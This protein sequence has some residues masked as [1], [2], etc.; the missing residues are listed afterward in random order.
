VRWL[1]TNQDCYIDPESKLPIAL[2]DYNISYEEPPEDIFDIPAIPDG[3]TLIDKRPGASQ[4]PESESTKVDRITEE[5]FKQAR[6]ALANGQYRLAAELFAKV[7]E[8][9]PHRGWAWFWLG[10]S[11]YELGEYNA[12]INDFSKVIDIFTEIGIV[13]HNCYLA[14]GFSYAAKGMTDMARRD[15]NVALPVMIGALSNIEGAFIFDYAD[16]PLFRDLP[17]DKRP[18]AQQSLTMM[19]NRLRKA[20]GHNFGYHPDATLEEKEQAIA[21]WEQ[22][23]KNSGQINFAPDAE[24]HHSP[25]TSESGDR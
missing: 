18:T 7:V 15:F 12:A 10:K 9:G 4:T 23:F 25:N 11:H 3:V 13:P 19:T 22:W 21:A 6:H 16:D 20:T 1:T 14:R 2:W 17:E 8:V 5:Q 24:I